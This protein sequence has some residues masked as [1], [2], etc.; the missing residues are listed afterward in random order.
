MDDW[1]RLV[2]CLVSVVVLLASLWGVHKRWHPLVWMS[3][4]LVGAILAISATSILYAPETPR[5]RGEIWVTEP[6]TPPMGC[7]DASCRKT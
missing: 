2:L 6:T 3:I 4:A 1:Q 5:L 7:F